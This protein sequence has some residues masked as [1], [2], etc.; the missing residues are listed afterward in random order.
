MK[1]EA[2]V[3]PT[4]MKIMA[5]IILLAVGLGIGVAVYRWAG[6]S[7]EEQLSFT[8]NVD[9]NEVIIGKPA[10][11]DNSKT[12][13]VNVEKILGGYNETVTLS[14]SPSRAGVTITFNP[15]SG[16]PNFGSTMTIIIDST[17]TPENVT[18]TVKGSG[19]DDLEKSDTFVLRIQ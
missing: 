14:Y 3:E 12:V 2:G 11:G 5:G 16:V 18:I 10:T 4:V 19:A 9:A 6:K 13:Q 7:I 15:S 1:D 8:V 17:A